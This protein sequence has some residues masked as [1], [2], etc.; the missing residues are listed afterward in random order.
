MR[1]I[2]TLVFVALFTS[3]LA[4]CTLSQDLSR[5]VRDELIQQFEAST[6]KLVSLSEAM[7]ADLYSWSPGEGVMTVGHVYAHIAKYNY[8]YLVNNLGVSP[9]KG[10]D[11]EN[12]E[13]LTEKEA[14]REALVKSI[15]FVRENTA[16]M[17]EGH[18]LKKTVLYGRDVPGWAVLV[19]LVAH[20]N[21]HVGQSVA[22]ARTNSV[23]PP[24]SR[25]A[26]M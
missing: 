18:L 23:V 25:P 6:R 19:Q 21:E 11:V 20:M 26:S 17:D 7:P 4:W 9:P 16:S 10:I 12:M 5:E 8:D 3:A 22:Y 14:I 2:S 13:E 1:R 15:E 24:W